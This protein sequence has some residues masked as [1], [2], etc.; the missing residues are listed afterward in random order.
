MRRTPARGGRARKISDPTKPWQP[1]STNINARRMSLPSSLSVYHKYIL[2]IQLLSGTLFH[3]L[4][5][6]QRISGKTDSRH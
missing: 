1:T 6:K 5:H 3:L 4:G 2:Q